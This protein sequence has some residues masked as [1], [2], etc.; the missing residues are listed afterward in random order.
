MGEDA[1]SDEVV[2]ALDLDIIDLFLTDRS[3]GNDLVETNPT[4]SLPLAGEGGDGD[5]H[6]GLEFADFFPDNGFP[7]HSKELADGVADDIFCYTI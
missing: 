6:A 7:A 2:S 5:L 3:D 1:V 4:L